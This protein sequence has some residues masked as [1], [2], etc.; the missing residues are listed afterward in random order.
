MPGPDVTVVD[1]HTHVVARD[2]ARF[3]LRPP[4]EL[5]HFREWYREA[6]V[7]VEGLL[8]EM[9]DA[10]VDRAVLVQAYSAYGTDNAYVTAAARAHADRCTSVAIV[11]GDAGGAR[12]LRTLAERDGV[13]GVRLFAIGNPSLERLDSDDAGPIWEV[14]QELGLRVV[15]TI[16]A[17]QFPELHTV[18]V[19]YPET[20][21]VLDHCGF[22]DLAGGD[23]F[24][25]AS[26]LF[27]LAALANLH[28]KVSSHL[29]ELA[30]VDGDPRDFVDRLAAE[31]GTERLL[32]G[33][34][35]P[36]THD[37]P[38]RALVD[39]GRHACSRL[40]DDAQCAF[41]GGNALRLWPEL[42]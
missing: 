36:Q 14:A 21:I 16:L 3:P 7:T 13:T 10:G 32:W 31:F 4:P 12:T 27:E 29:L 17:R 2:E 34:D 5:P 42:A 26:A 18:L 9:G 39:L 24:P 19:R 11:E 35:Y 8:A 33:S 20:P 37:R 41:L 23:G 6:P 40:P 22:P 15:A 38:Y 28:L 1:T 30:E 25:H